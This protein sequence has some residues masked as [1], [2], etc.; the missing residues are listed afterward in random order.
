MWSVVFTWVILV[1]A[2]ASQI[3]SAP[4]YNMSTTSVGNLSGIAPFIGSTLRTFITE[5]A[6]DKIAEYLASRNDGVY[7]PEFRLF[8]IIPAFAAIAVG[9]FGLGAAIDKALP[10]VT[11][12]VYLAIINFSVGAGCTGIVTYTNDVCNHRAGEAF[13]LAMV[14][15]P[16]FQLVKVHAVSNN[17]PRSSKALWPLASHSYSTTITLHIDLLFSSRPSPV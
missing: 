2:V 17:G 1:G 11:C 9:G 10:A 14:G 8:I 12:G 4:P 15:Q 16:L 13:G 5:W 6:Y 3:F 7:E